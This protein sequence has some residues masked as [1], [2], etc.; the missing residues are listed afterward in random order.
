MPDSGGQSA[1]TVRRDG[2]VEFVAIDRAGLRDVPV[3][4]QALDNQW[5]PRELLKQAFQAGSVSEEIDR[6]RSRLAR[7]EYI[8]A[9]ING[10]QVVVNRAFLYNNPV[11]SRDFVPDAGERDK[12]VAER[13]EAFRGLLDEG[14]LVPFLLYERSPLEEPEFS[15]V[16]FD[17]WTVL[18]RDVRM[19]CARLS[20][21]DEANGRLIATH[22]FGRFEEFMMTM[23]SEAKDPRTYVHELGLE[24]GLEQELVRRLRSVT[25]T[26][27]DLRDRDRRVTREE[28]YRAFVT[29][30]GTRPAERRF[31]ARKAFAPAVKQLLDLAYSVNLPDALD[32]YLLTPV[33]SPARAALQ[34]IA[35]KTTGETNL[36]T[37][38][39]IKR[40]LQRR[41]FDEVMRGA[42][43]ESMDVLTLADVRDLRRTPQWARYIRRLRALLDHP[44][45]FAE[46]G[47][48]SVLRAYGELAEAMKPIMHRRYA[49]PAERFLARA[50]LVLELSIAIGAHLAV[51]VGAPGTD[52][53]LEI[54]GAEAISLA[55]A[56][57]L[58]CVVR[59][60]IRDL[61]SR[62]AGRDLSHRV[63]LMKGG[64]ENA[65]AAWPE[66]LAAVRQLSQ[67]AGDRE[68][69]PSEDRSPTMNSP[70]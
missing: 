37:P 24:A 62:R 28:L 49:G 36:I 54:F 34:E 31:D 10:E 19:T 21:D 47:A 66:I 2:D 59:F 13:R 48:Q 27:L 23:A 43:V 7:S 22:L 63:E 45:S 5:L 65:E 70:E 39:E 26:V 9:L 44:E 32:G 8:R 46:G 58:P 33:D 68:G 53:V 42:Y 56:K 57:T 15:T 17:A 30:A 51:L 25:R 18:S 12:D 35:Q 6:T 61:A 11:I 67:G 38:D 3:F 60:G 40:L 16:G 64:I 41:A 52:P 29:A 55:G 1:G 20:W 50:E 69:Q 14:V 4:S